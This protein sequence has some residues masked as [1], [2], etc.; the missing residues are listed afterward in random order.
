MPIH[1]NDGFFY[2]LS[3]LTQL[4]CFTSSYIRESCLNIPL[5]LLPELNHV[6]LF[7]PVLMFSLFF[8]PF[9]YNFHG[10]M[11]MV[12]VFCQSTPLHVP[13]FVAL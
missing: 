5:I 12:N 11:G 2:L 9:V 7:L 8:L 10:N 1:F 4:F 6:R 13:Q 3:H